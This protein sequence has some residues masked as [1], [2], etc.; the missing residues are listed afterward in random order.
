MFRVPGF[1]DGLFFPSSTQ[2]NINR[3]KGGYHFFT[4]I[5]YRESANDTNLNCFGSCYSSYHLEAQKLT[6][7]HS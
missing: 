6:R 1:I 3:S 7:F 4:V 5:L 2:K